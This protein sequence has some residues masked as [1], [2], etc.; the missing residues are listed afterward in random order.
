MRIKQQLVTNAAAQELEDVKKTAAERRIILAEA[1]GKRLDLA[2][3]FFEKQAKERAAAAKKAAEE[4]LKGRLAEIEAEHHQQDAIIKLRQAAML[5]RGDER[6]SELSAIFTEGQLKIAALEANARKEIAQLTGTAA[7]KKA[8]AL[9]LEKELGAEVALVKADVLKKQGELVDKF[10]RA[11]VQRLEKFIDEQVNAIED[12]AVRQQAAFEVMLDAGLQSQQQAD[13][14]K[15]EARQAAFADEL[16]LIESSLGKESAAYKK[17]F[18]TMVKDQADFGK[19]EVAEREKAFKAKRQLQNMEMATAGDVLNFGLELLGQD[20]DARK[21][22][23]SLYTALAAAK[24][25]VDGTKEVQQIWEYS[26]ENPANGPSAGTAGIIMGG[27]QTAVAVGR[28]AVALS[29]LGGGGGGGGDNTSYAQGGAT[30]TGAGL[31]VSPWGQLMAMSGMSVGSSGKLHDGS[32][33]AVAG[34]VHEDEY[35]IPKWQL[36]DPQVAAVAQWLEAR[37]LRGFADGGHTS[38]RSGAALSVAAA[39]P[40]TDGERTYAVQTQMLDALLVMGQQLG[41][42][43][44]WQRDLQVRLDLRAAQASLDEYKQ[45]QHSSAIRSKA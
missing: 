20:A 41:D 15:Y 39:S 11:D 16:A 35:V 33:F 8:R 32:G 38:A 31:A 43:K 30:G 2:R 42:V 22:H 5:A 10:N 6:V 29:K 21:K 17:V 12:Q 4:S 37:R 26:A 40:S 27:I 13:R 3:T 18:G 34:V 25:I 14:A 24:I 45:V 7:Q 36:A 28:T 23:H 19:K 1:E 44:Q 9:D